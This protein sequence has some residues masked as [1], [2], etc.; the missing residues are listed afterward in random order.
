[1]V[2]RWAWEFQNDYVLASIM[3]NGGDILSEDEER[4]RGTRRC[5][6]WNGDT[7]MEDLSGFK[8]KIMGIFT[9]IYI[10]YINL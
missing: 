4:T 3:V 9:R 2:T 5:W 7:K 10:I 8:G 1:V 6:G